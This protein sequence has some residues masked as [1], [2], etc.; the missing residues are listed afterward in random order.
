MADRDYLIPDSES[1]G[2]PNL[3][4]L[5]PVL[6]VAEDDKRPKAYSIR[7]ILGEIPDGTVT[8]SMLA[9][10]VRDELGGDSVSIQYAETD[11]ADDDDWHATKTDDDEWIRVGL[12]DPAEYSVGIPLA[13]PGSVLTQGDGINISG[14]VISISNDYINDLIGA[15]DRWVEHFRLPYA[16]PSN[17]DSVSNDRWKTELVSGDEYTITI[18]PGTHNVSVVEGLSEDAQVQVRE[19]SGTTIRST[20][21]LTE[22][23]TGPNA[24]DEYTLTGEWDGTAF[25]NNS[26]NYQLYFSQSRSHIQSDLDESDSNHPAYVRGSVDAGKIADDAITTA[27]IAD[28]AVTQDKLASGVGGG[29]PDDGSADNRQT[30]RRCCLRRQR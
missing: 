6:P 13:E 17:Y 5:I 24:D 9:Q 30:C 18:I 15:S 11:S 25:F 16:S 14:D 28:G 29:T 20:F 23:A 19:P 8:E 12:G 27:K 2:T 4:D 26:A 1:S 21:T 3:S 10:A 22:D 7:T